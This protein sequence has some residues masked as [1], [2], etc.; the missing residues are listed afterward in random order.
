M[1]PGDG[2]SSLLVQRMLLP[3]DDDE[4]M[5][6]KG[7]AVPADEIQKVITWINEGAYGPG[8]EHIKRVATNADDE[9]R[10]DPLGVLE[11][12]EAEQALIERAVAALR[13]RGAVV[14]AVAQRHYGL[15][16]NLS[17]LRPAANDEHLKLLRGLEPVLVRLDLSRTAVTD[18]GFDQL[19]GFPELR[20]LRLGGTQLGDISRVLQGSPKLERLNLYGTRCTNKILTYVANLESLERLHIWGSRIT[21]D[22]AAAFASTH[23]EI[24]ITGLP[25][26]VRK[27][28]PEVMVKPEPLE[29]FQPEPFQPETTKDDPKLASEEVNF[30][31]KIKPIFE[32]RCVS[33]HGSK[34]KKGGLRLDPIADA[35]PEGDEDWWTILPGDPAGSLLIERIKLSEDDD[36]V[37]PPRGELLSKEEI[38][39][40]EQWIAQ[41]AK[42]SN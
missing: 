11:P 3:R 35:F 28:I 18:Q 25:L 27:P 34:K 42:H 33:C 41:G 40:I 1:L 21:D 13:D 5:P 14:Q 19:A 39:I 15:E 37:M 24:R 32:A 6:P 12:T 36:G 22:F 29:E 31:T 16:V 26:V 10:Q 2:E 20:D 7:D 30:L 38:S 9:R 4:A 17:L 8:L 23:P